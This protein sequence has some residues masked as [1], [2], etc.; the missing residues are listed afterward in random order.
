MSSALEKT[1]V[2]ET[3]E[4]MP[5][6]RCRGASVL[7]GLSQ[8]SSQLRAFAGKNHLRFWTFF[9]DFIGVIK[10]SCRSVSATESYYRT[11]TKPS[12]PSRPG[13]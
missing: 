5:I 11:S 13:A 3:L 4:I 8:C 6:G 7:L 2:V 9:G 1:K 10:R 12:S